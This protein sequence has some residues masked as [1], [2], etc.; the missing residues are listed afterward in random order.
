M[1]RGLSGLRGKRVL[2]TGGTSGIGLA[3]A[4]RFLDEGCRIFTCGRDRARLDAALQ[5]LETLGEAAGMTCDVSNE[6]EI[7]ELVASAVHALGGVDVLINNAGTSW[8]EPFLEITPS[9]GIASSRS[10]CWACF[11]ARRSRA[12]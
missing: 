1:S 2:I 12:E 7:N 9:I 3:T 6:E 10:T 4:R 8:R 11:S 5:N